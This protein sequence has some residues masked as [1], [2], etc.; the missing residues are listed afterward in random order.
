MSS[1]T[2]TGHAKNVANFEDLISFCTGYGATYNP[3]NVNI[4]I[5]ALNS[6]Y[7]ACVNAILAVKVAKTAFDNSTNSRELVFASLKKL[8]TRVVNALEATTAAK[9]TV[10]D[11]KTVNRKIQGKRASKVPEEPSDGGGTGAE[12][13]V[14][15]ISVSQQSYDS[16]IDH[17]IKLIQIVSTEPLYLPNETDLKVVTL[18]ALLVSLKAANTS[19]IGTTTSYSNSR[20]TRDS[21]L[22]DV[23]T[24]MVD[25]AFEVKAYVKSLYGAGSMQYKQVSGLKFTKIK[26][27]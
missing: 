5:P 19:V 22:Y 13:P 27:S 26:H 9:V 23:T 4:K 16:L 8:S 21:A 20:I 18:N 7:T 6:K 15:T 12:A 24:G 2:E 10:D 3:V 11:A 14:K 25:L 17:F 1:F